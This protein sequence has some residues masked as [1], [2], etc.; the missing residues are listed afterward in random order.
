MNA[1]ADPDAGVGSPVGDWEVLVVDEEA[2]GQDRLSPGRRLGCRLACAVALALA[3]LTFCVGD[4]VIRSVVIHGAHLSWGLVEWSWTAVVMTVVRRDPWMAV[5]S[6][7]GATVVCCMIG[8]WLGGVR[9]RRWP[10]DRGRGRPRQQ[11]DLGV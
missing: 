2:R 10:E 11:S 5:S 9:R 3:P 6:L 1:E 8:W 4:V 7:G